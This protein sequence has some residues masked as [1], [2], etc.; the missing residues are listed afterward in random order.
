M[1]GG[2]ERRGKYELSVVETCRRYSFYEYT[3]YHMPS[4]N[5]ARQEASACSLNDKIYAFCGN[6]VGTSGKM[7]LLKSIEKLQAC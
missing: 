4:L 1:I 7:K 3:W 2:L 5:F 6:Q